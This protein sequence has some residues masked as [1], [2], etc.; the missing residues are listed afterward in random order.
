VAFEEVRARTEIET[1][2]QLLDDIDYYRLLLVSRTAALHEIE[3]AFRAQ[4]KA[5]HPDHFFALEQAD[6]KSKAQE[7][8]RR[9]NEAWRTLKDPALREAYDRELRTNGGVRMSAAQRE[10]A[11][12]AKKQ[13]HDVSEVAWIVGTHIDPLR[14]VQMTKGPVDDL[15]DAVDLPAYGGKMGIDATRKWPSEGYTRSWPER[16]ATTESA[17]RKAAR[18]KR[19]AARGRIGR[20]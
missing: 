13:K 20:L 5:L 15:D 14:D 10:L 17:G 16:I 18:A 3:T 7:I 6:L 11:E 2:H 8:F 12:R 1:L 4:T 19:N 9:V